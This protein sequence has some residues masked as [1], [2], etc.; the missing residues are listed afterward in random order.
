MTDEDVQ[1][2]DARDDGPGPW[3]ADLGTWGAVALIAF[4][5]LAAAWVYFRLPGTPEELAVGYYQA[6]RIIAIGSV[7]VGCTVLGRR[8]DRTA[9]A[10]ETAE[11]E[12]A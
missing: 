11:P 4:G 10:E 3:W 9:A 12:G 7:I 8:R 6:A 2:T 1:Q 5:A